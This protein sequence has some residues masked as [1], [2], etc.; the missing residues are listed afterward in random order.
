M[1]KFVIA[2]AAALPLLTGGCISTVTS[3]VTAPVKVASK[4]V[5]W[6]TTSQ[7]EADRNYGKKARKSEEREG[8]ERRAYDK[9]CKKDPRN[10]G[11]YEG[12]RADPGGNSR[13]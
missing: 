9:Q 4:A 13:R 3:I 10:C 8:R 5:D 1:R 12:Y 2:A 7:S 6:T 11:P